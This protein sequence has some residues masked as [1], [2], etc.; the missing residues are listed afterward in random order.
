MTAHFPAYTFPFDMATMTA[1]VA[2]KAATLSVLCVHNR[3]IQP[4]GEDQVFESESRLLAENG[5]RVEKVEE[6]TTY[7]NGLVRKIEAAVDC[8]WSRSWHQE[9][10]SILRRV[11]PDVVHIHNF[12]SVMSPSIYYACK[13]EGVP[14][15][16]TLHNYRLACPAASFYRDGK[17]CEECIDRGPFHAVKYGCYRDS[18]L[19]TAALAA[20][21]EVHRR[22]HTWTEMIDCYVALTEFARK[23][24]IQAGLPAEKIVVKPNFVL[25]DPGPRTGDGDYALFVGR[26]VDLKGVGTLIKAWSK[27]PASIP[28]VVAGDGPFRPE[29][30]KFISDLNLKNVDYRGRLSRQH[31]LAAMKGARFLMFPSEWYEGFPVTIAESFACGV[32]VIC[33]RLGGMQEIVADGRT[34]LHFTAGDAA[35]MAEKAKWAW[36]NRDATRAMGFAA[37]AEFEAKYSAERNFGMLTQIYEKVIAHPSPSTLPA[38]GARVSRVH[39]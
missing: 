6:Q 4:G 15:V 33:S 14:V 39:S 1:P 11:K 13:D 35:D 3:Y 10:K 23:K 18:K 30:E 28:L 29:M 8:V 5:V 36:S 19:A 25:P 26:L 31:T 12:F 34:G 21:I 20:M 9:F 27:L 2:V 38:E 24:M 17:V 32:P 22:K 16:Q 7:P 37:R